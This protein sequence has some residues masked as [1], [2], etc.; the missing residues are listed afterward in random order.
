MPC[1]QG[2]R[3]DPALADERA[4]AEGRRTR[5]QRHEEVELAGVIDGF[6]ADDA[7]GVQVAREHGALATFI[8]AFIA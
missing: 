8:I 2:R 1:V 4:A 6:A 7:A 5:L 3:Q